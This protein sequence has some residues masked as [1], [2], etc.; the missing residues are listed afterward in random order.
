MHHSICYC[1]HAGQ[2][3]ASIGALLLI[4][5][6]PARSFSALTLWNKGWR[7]RILVPGFIIVRPADLHGILAF[8]V[9][10]R[11]IFLEA[12]GKNGWRRMPR[13]ATICNETPRGSPGA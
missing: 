9:M 10:L 12:E 2:A 4:L 8:P 6:N 1:A 11:Q 5:S 7:D 13:L 3:S